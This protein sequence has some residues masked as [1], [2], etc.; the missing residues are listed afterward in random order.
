MDI[1]ESGE[2]MEK[3]KEQ[4]LGSL[5][6]LVCDELTDRIG[7]GDATPTDLNVA[8]QLLKDNNITAHPAA[9]SPLEQ[10]SNALPFPSGEDVQQAAG[11]K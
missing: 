2:R 9:A 5:F 6:D 10:L 8:R 7:S 3:T 4:K 11:I 1:R